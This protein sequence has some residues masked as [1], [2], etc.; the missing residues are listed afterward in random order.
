[1]GK[2]LKIFE[3][4]RGSQSA[5]VLEKNPKQKITPKIFLSQ[6]I[7]FEIFE[8]EFFEEFLFKEGTLKISS[9]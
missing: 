7:T 6:K 3:P 5:M 8:I 2:K 4:N 9:P 1:M